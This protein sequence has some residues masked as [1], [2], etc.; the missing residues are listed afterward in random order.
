MNYDWNYHGMNRIFHLGTANA[1]SISARQDTRI[2]MRTLFSA[3]AVKD[4]AAIRRLWS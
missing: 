3:A 4:M 1:A 2:L